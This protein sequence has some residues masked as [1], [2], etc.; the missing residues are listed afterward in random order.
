MGLR[1]TSQYLYKQTSQIN[2]KICCVEI[3]QSIIEYDTRL[4]RIFFYSSYVINL[5]M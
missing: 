1:H 2:P 3:R 4:T 5:V